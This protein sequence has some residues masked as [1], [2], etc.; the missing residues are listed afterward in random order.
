MTGV[1]LLFALGLVLLFFEVVVPGG[2]L[3]LL[4][5]V[6]MLVGCGVAFAEFGQNGGVAAT[7]FALGLISLTLYL[8]LVVLPKTRWGRKLFLDRAIAAQSQP[9]PANADEVVGRTGEALTTLAPTGYVL[10][11]GKK[12]E[13]ASRSGLLPK[14]TAV[15]VTGLDN[16]RLIVSKS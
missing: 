13:A 16:F 8:E 14:G 11:A 10:V 12:Y 4:G 15:K 9:P 7:V 2:V 3:G 5:A 6:L 1:I